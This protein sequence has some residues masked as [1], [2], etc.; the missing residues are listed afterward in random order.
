MLFGLLA[1]ALPTAE[2]AS[3]TQTQPQSQLKNR[4]ANAYFSTKLTNLAREL[5][6]AHWISVLYVFVWCFGL[7]TLLC[8]VAVIAKLGLRSL[9]FLAPVPIVAGIY[10]AARSLRGSAASE[11]DLP[12]SPETIEKPQT[13][14][15]CWLVLACLIVGLRHIPSAYLP[16][17]ILSVLFLIAWRVFGKARQEANHIGAQPSKP[18]T[19]LLVVVA[20]LSAGLTFVAHRPDADDSFYVGVISD[21]VAHPD[22]PVLQRDCL[23]GDH[24]FPLVLPGY[25]VDSIEMFAAILAGTFGGVRPIPPSLLWAHTGVPVLC[26]LLLP[27]AWAF[28]LQTVTRRWLEASIVALVLLALL[29][30][31]PHSLGNFAYVR[32][33]QGKAVLAS[34]GIPLIYAF[35]WKFQKTGRAWDWA[36]LG[37]SSIAVL[38][39][40]AAGLFLVPMALGIAGVAS[41]QPKANWRT[42]WLLMPGLYPIVWGIALSS[43]M[44]SDDF[45]VQQT[46]GDMIRDV[47]GPR[48]QYLMFLGL[49]TAPLFGEAERIRRRLTYAA[50]LYLLGP[51]NP[52]LFP[53]ISK[54]TGEVV[55]RTLWSLPVVG[56]T[57]LS[58]LGIF[59]EARRRWQSPR[60]AGW[61]GIERLSYVIPILAVLAVTGVLLLH[62]T[63]RESNAVSFSFSPY[64][65]PPLEWRV[66]TAASSAA[67]PFTSVLAPEQ[68]AAWIPILMHRPE[69]VSVRANYDEQMGG[70]MTPADAANRRELRELVTGRQF[71]AGHVHEL[72][73]TLPHYRVSVLVVS[74]SESKLL[75]SELAAEGYSVLE[76]LDGYV[77]WSRAPQ[78]HS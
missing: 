22:S 76:T 19:K 74:N 57:A 9:I 20:V 16:F 42:L 70:R 68:I 48:G 21:S 25:K 52:F 11:S 8:H 58:V 61:P 75:S 23:Y 60:A 66:A 55:F 30:E 43:S 67:P 56:F 54:L 17:W 77:L 50:L 28:F 26:A 73:Q 45:T 72:L 53:L 71:P 4:F 7:W 39:L 15:W 69:L 78:P 1:M 64:K 65:L 36:T 63:L 3:S 34:A 31:T 47:F 29:G 40:S 27:F 18:A 38:G 5:R 12:N 35:A 41:W 46:I 33:F 2:S 62:S 14:C 10:C 6:A 44:V 24:Q 32:F 37:A 13:H 51:L 49:L 59:S